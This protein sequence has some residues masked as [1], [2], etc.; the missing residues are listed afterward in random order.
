MSTPNKTAAIKTFYNYDEMNVL[1][2][3]LEGNEMRAQRRSRTR[4]AMDIVQRVDLH[5]ASCDD[6]ARANC[7]DTVRTFAAMHIDCKVEALR[8]G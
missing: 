3:S 7:A 6:K 1:A 2:D 4:N 5:C 8:V